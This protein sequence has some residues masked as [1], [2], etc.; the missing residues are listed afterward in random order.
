[1]ANTRAKSIA[2]MRNWGIASLTELRGRLNRLDPL[3]LN[4]SGRHLVEAVALE[5]LNCWIN[6]MRGYCLTA[7]S[8]GY[9][10]DGSRLP[11]ISKA[12]TGTRALTVAIHAQKPNLQAR[13]G[14]WTY[15]DEP[16]WGDASIVAKI[17]FDLNCP[18]AADFGAAVSLGS[19]ARPDLATFR[20]YVAHRNRGTALKVRDLAIRYSVDPSLEPLAIPL[21]IQRLRTQP[22]MMDWLDDLLTMAEL[23]PS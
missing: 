2:I 15:R 18:V 16:D 20:N 8:G 12:R 3:P 22:I 23:L 11:K 6:L 17:L 9:R 19:S 1:M 5:T 13:V 10:E 7:V 14:P 21:Q 4:E